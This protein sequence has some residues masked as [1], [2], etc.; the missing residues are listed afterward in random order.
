MYKYHKNRGVKKT[1]LH[2]IRHTFATTWIVSGGSPKKL[3][4][5]L[6]QKSSVIVDKYVHMCANDLIDDFE[7][8]TPIGKIKDNLYSKTKLSR[9]RTR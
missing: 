6:G 8:F 1:S 7:E 3:Q 2:L 9:A 5:A 4:K